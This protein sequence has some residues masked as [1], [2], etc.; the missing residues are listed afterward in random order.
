V[1]CRPMKIT[2][3]TTAIHFNVARR[4]MAIVSSNSASA[5]H[6]IERRDQT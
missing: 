5:R 6:L 3:I 4:D 2:A 1:N